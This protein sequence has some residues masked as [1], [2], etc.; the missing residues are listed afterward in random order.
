M[1]LI[2]K[3][4]VFWDVHAISLGNVMHNMTPI[5]SKIAVKTKNLGSY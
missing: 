4:K 2:Q 3:R 5:F 1:D